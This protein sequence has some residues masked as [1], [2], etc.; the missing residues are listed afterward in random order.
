[1]GLS[2]NNSMTRH[3]PRGNLSRN[4][5]KSC[6]FRASLGYNSFYYIRSL[7]FLFFFLSFFH[8]RLSPNVEVGS[9][10][11]PAGIQTFNPFQIPL[12]NTAILLASGATVTRA[13]HAIIDSNHSQAIQRLALTSF[14]GVYFTALQALEYFEAPFTIAD[15]VYGSTFLWPLDFM[16]FTLL[17]E[18]LS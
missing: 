9:C 3:H 13:H 14:L 8:R 4:T 11:P 7:I 10:W 2:D 17:L 12:L 5:H 1:M 15:S 18:A 6:H 16:G